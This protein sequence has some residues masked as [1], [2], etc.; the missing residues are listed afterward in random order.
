VPQHL[1][2]LIVILVLAAIGFW[3][4]RRQVV[5]AGIGEDDFVRR[6]NTWFAVTCLAF[7]PGNF[8]IFAAGSALVLW[9]VAR[10]DSNPFALYLF[11]L[12]A[13]PP[14]DKAIPGFGII[15]Y[16]I[17]LDYLRLLSLAVLLPLSLR[18]QA[19]RMLLTDYLVLGYVLLQLVLRAPNDT[20]TNLARWTF[21]AFIDV[22]L[23]YFVASRSIRSYEDLRDVL[24]SFAA[25]AAIIGLLAVFESVRAWAL[26]SVIPDLFDAEFGYR[27]YLRRAGTLRAV[28]STGQAIVLGYVMAL[29]AIFLA[30]AKFRIRPIIWWLGMLALVGGALASMSRGPVIGLAAGWLAMRLIGPDALKGAFK[31]MAGLVIFFGGLL[32]SPFGPQLLEYVP[33]IGSIDEHNVLY[34][35]RLFE[36]SIDLI[37]G[38]PWT[39]V[40]NFYGQLV[41]LG[42]KQGQ[43]IVDL[44]NTYLTIALAYGVV[45]LILFVGVFVS[46]LLPLG[47]VLIVRNVLPRDIHQHGAVIFGALI[48]ALLIIATA[49]SVLIVPYLYWILA[50]LGVGYL[51]LVRCDLPARSN[52]RTSPG[53][54][55]SI[56]RRMHK[57]RLGDLKR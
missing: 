37:R 11:V 9:F 5:A 39:G 17:E 28:G 22:G 41:D 21:Y 47:R 50:G 1:R 43:G 48:A 13:V 15:N 49:S 42:M 14:I 56:A 8:W 53:G 44:V 51:Q 18:L 52:H 35:Q 55:P 25:G 40:Y 20:G 57:S 54:D 23:P 32:I 36:T 2:A 31:L 30:S 27:Q 16:V 38:S 29:G 6:R 4:M 12:L 3:L 33:F 7:I 19:G 10:R 24:L 26:Y 46:V 34:R 45:A